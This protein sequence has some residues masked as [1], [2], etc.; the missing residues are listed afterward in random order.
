[1]YD[2][3]EPDRIW[4]LLADKLSGEAGMKELKELQEL[5]KEY[6]AIEECSKLLGGIWRPSGANEKAIKMLLPGMSSRYQ[7]KDK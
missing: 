1:M 3:N 2:P 4:F 5:E 7:I 6:P